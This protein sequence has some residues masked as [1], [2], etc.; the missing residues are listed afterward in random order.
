MATKFPEQRVVFASWH[1]P[2]DIRDL[3]E[4][5]VSMSLSIPAH[6]S[7]PSCTGF[8]INLVRHGKTVSTCHGA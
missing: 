6:A 5:L 3:S 1:R 8:D 7:V 4:M 2:R